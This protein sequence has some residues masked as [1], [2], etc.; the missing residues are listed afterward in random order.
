MSTVVAPRPD[1]DWKIAS[2][3]L[4]ASFAVMLAL[5]WPGVVKLVNIWLNSET[6]AHGLLIV[7]ISLYL[8]WTRRKVVA[9]LRPQPWLWALPLLA[10]LAFAWLA[11]R[12]V[13]VTVVQTFIV[14]AMVPALV[15]AVM[16]PAVARALMFPLGFLFF[17]W[18]VGTF[19]VPILQDYTGWLSVLLLKLSGIPVHMEGRFISIPVGNFVVAEAC[20]GIR[21]LFASVALGA[22]YAY[23]MYHSI[24]RRL[25]LIGLAILLP[26]IANGLRAYGIIMIAHWS[27]ME[28]AVGVD[29]L[30]Y[31]WVFFLFVMLLLF[32]IGGLFREPRS[33]GS[34]TSAT[35]VSPPLPPL[36]MRAAALPV[37][38]VIVVMALGPAGD[39]WMS[40]RIAALD[41]DHR[42]LAYQVQGWEGPGDP[43]DDWR[44]RFSEPDRMVQA[45]YA[46]DNAMIGLNLL[47]YRHDVRDGD[48][49]HY[50]N[51]IHDGDEW[52]RTSEARR[53]LRLASGEILDVREMVMRGRNGYRMV[54]YWYQVTGT[55]TIH[56]ITVK[57]LEAWA[58]LSGNTEG[59]LLIALSIDFQ[60]SADDARAQLTDFVQAGDPLIGFDMNGEAR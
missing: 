56:P 38:A 19:L 46:R 50:A 41:T 58:R 9:A 16:G 36:A 59:S 60:V 15:M 51:R 55:A 48:L 18:P 53:Q 39:G 21:Y 57:L 42:P 17:A 1:Y 30:L 13:D 32:W 8:A 28:H 33:T 10:L 2:A 37:L 31:G 5:Y 49:I 47:H 54:W 29:H 25:A 23:L 14:I 44:P 11:A 45:S 34:A 4:V 40:W 20:S 24:W 43:V 3:V 52:R 26:I 22:V 7:P 6:Y 12:L 35:S 27:D